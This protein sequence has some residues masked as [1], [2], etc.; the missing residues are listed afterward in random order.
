MTHVLI[1]VDDT[2]SSVT[3]AQTAHRL[4]GDDA[5]YTVISVSQSDPVYWGDD[6]LGSGV[7]YPLAVPP[8]GAGMGMATMPLAVRAPDRPRESDIPT[9]VE[10]AE[11]TARHVAADVGIH[12]ARPIGDSGDAAKAI[13]EAADN[14]DADVI[15]VG[16]HDRSWLD[17]LFNPSVAEQVVKK[18]DTPVLVAR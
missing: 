4:F 17:R 9:P 16:S 11:Q 5:D 18:S 15:V 8:V 7:V 10:A 3:A 14:Y 13:L 2:E 6:P 1:A 12:E